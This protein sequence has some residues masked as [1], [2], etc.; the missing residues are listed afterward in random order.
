[1]ASKRRTNTPAR[2][3]VAVAG[4]VD[5]PA[6]R[7]RSTRSR[8]R[9]HLGAALRTSR[10]GV[11]R[12]TT[13]DSGAERR[14]SQTDARRC[15]TTT[16]PASSRGRHRRPRRPRSPRRRPPVPVR[17]EVGAHCVGD[18]VFTG[19]VTEDL[20]AARSAR[21]AALKKAANTEDRRRPKPKSPLQTTTKVPAASTITRREREPRAGRRA[22]TWA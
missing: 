14:R 3:P 21:S 2:R 17:R 6:T 1:M 12:P 13:L 5:P 18:D 22:E 15:P 8:S 9:R 4:L 19:R 20:A 16:H 10:V 7:P 11:H